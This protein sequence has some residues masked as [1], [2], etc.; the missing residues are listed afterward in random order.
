MTLKFVGA[1]YALALS[2]TLYGITTGACAQT[3]PAAEQVS[4]APNLNQPILKV[5]GVTTTNG[6]EEATYTL[7]D[8]EAIG[9]E[10]IE[11]TTPWFDGVTKFEGVRLDKLLKGAKGK[12]VEAVAMNDY[13]S[14][15]PMEDFAKYGTIIAYKRNGA[16]M[17]IRDK[18]PLFIVYPYDKISELKSQKFYSRSVWQV[19]GLVVK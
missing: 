3:A 8:L 17:P 7:Q 12:T 16:Y 6:T 18:G 2:L 15:I 11:T 9:G 19:K 1:G 5:A 10:V 13:V 4:T 14:E